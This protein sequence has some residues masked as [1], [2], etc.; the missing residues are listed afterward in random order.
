MSGAKKVLYKFTFG[1]LIFL[2]VCTFLSKSIASSFQPEV[3]VIRAVTTDLTESDEYIGEAVYDGAYDIA[4]DYPVIVTGVSVRAGDAVS[5]GDV[6]LEVENKEYYLEMKRK[7]LNILKV[8]STITQTSDNDLIAELNL[9]LEIEEEE[10]NIYK[11][12][13]PTDGKIY[14]KTDGVVYGV[15]ARENET[16]SPGVSLIGIYDKN[17]RSTVAFYL[18]EKDAQKYGPQDE[19]VLYYK[20]NGKSVAPETTVRRKEYDAAANTYR[21]SAPI[22][23]DYVKHNQSIPLKVTHRTK[24]YDIVIPLMA[25]IPGGENKN[26]VCTAKERQGLFGLEYYIK[27]V[28]VEIIDHNSTHAAIGGWTVTPFDDVILSSSSYLSSGETVKV[29][30]K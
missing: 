27:Y 9:Q 11:E 17:S 28:E 26:Y 23:S 4:F 14:A 22:K 25:I 8:K 24:I 5:E 21:Y 3:E 12:K 20:E 15:N 7:E 29:I 30:N 6:L 19:V 2:A 10:L 1:V 13:Y 16:I 18:S